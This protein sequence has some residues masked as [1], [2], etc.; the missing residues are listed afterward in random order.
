MNVSSRGC[1][2]AS[3]CGEYKCV[4]ARLCAGKLW[5]MWEGRDAIRSS[6]TALHAAQG[7]VNPLQRLTCDVVYAA[8]VLKRQ[9]V[10]IPPPPLVLLLLRRERCNTAGEAHT[11]L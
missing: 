4:V 5:R 3:C 1:V 2:R 11:T 9:V 8:V 10:L 7:H 6:C